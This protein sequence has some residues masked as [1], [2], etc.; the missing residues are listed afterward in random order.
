MKIAIL[1]LLIL[2]PLAAYGTTIN[3]TTDEDN[4]SLIGGSGV[5]LREAIKYS[6]T[7]THITFAP[8]LSGQTLDLILGEIAFPFSSPVNLIIDAS[9]LPEPVTIS[10]YELNRIFLV[11]TSATVEM[12]SL[13][14]TRGR[15]SGDGGA[16]WNWGACT[17]ISCELSENSADSSGGAIYNM[18]SATFTVTSSTLS[19]NVS[20]LGSGGG[21]S[22]AGTLVMRNSTLSGN[23]AY[24]SGGGLSSTGSSTVASSTISGNGAITSGGGVSNTGTLDLKFSIVAGNFA[25]A[26]S[27][28][29]G[30][31]PDGNNLLSGDPALTPL[32]DY[33][34]PV[35]TMHPLIGSPAI[36]AGGA[37]DSAA[38]DARGF[39][40]LVDGDANGNTSLD[41]GAVEAGPLLTVTSSL[42][43]GAP[44]TLRSKINAGAATP[45][46][47]IGFSPE[48]FPSQT[49]RLTRGPLGIFDNV[50][51]FIDASNLSGAVTI[52]G[53]KS[54]T[55]FILTAS[56]N[57]TL[58]KLNI[59]DG[60]S[61]QNGGGIDN[62]GICNALS[63]SFT[64]N[65]ASS[66]GGGI[67][68]RGKF[69]MHACTLSGN[70]AS[71]GGGIFILGSYLLHSCTLAGNSAL[72]GGGIYN[73]GRCI[74]TYSTLSGN[75]AQD[76]GG[77]ISNPGGLDITYSIVALNSAAF[78]ADID[79]F[80]Y[81]SDK[82]IMGVDPILSPL[83]DYGGPTK[84]M[85]PL[86]GSPAIDGGHSFNRR[87]ADQRGFPIGANPDLGAAEY[88]GTGD[89]TRFWPLDFDGDSSPY[90]IEQ[91]LGTN[92]FVSDHANSRNITVPVLNT[93]GRPVLSFGIGA[94][95]PGTRWILSR[96]TNLRAFT[97]IY[98]FNGITDT[99]APDIAFERT[100]TGVI[101]TDNTPPS[102]AAFYR[103]EA[104]L[105]N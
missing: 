13:R 20:H 2:F 12:R 105:D 65:S 25:P 22:N 100:A 23:R 11:P 95:A 74:V 42:D 101:V 82:V 76:F 32:G 35:R 1:T 31:A 39:P 66:D 94:A 59:A 60:R 15:A 72:V 79:G 78:S 67:Y 93:S 96:S 68:S 97:E 53:G 55:V 19:G 58:C 88:Q 40:R 27:N 10:A 21:L 85:V 64:G 57:L 104:L 5:S 37:T 91:A 81:T 4:G 14:M 48:K 62:Q 98:R 17:L 38:T 54:S 9:N 61:S 46:T 24:I 34:G 87:T 103:F 49:I 7:G 90:G 50:N 43:T 45:G 6:P 28:V 71:F 51:L 84:T 41:F 92:P 3:I 56:A 36:D 52:S 69:S 83:G 16:I 102:G 44:E 33:G 8:H 89:L 47:R 26:D 70:S 80:H 99:A 30:F 63:C 73:A 18:P 75:T 77:G 29:I 86:H